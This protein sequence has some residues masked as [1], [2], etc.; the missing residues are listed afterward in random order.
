MILDGKKVSLKILQEIKKNIEAIQGLKP[1]L[2]VVL[3]GDDPASSIYVKMKRKAC[4]DSGINS[5]FIHLDSSIDEEHLI[6]EIKKLNN[7]DE[8]HGILVQFPLP[9]HIN[10][11]RVVESIIPSKDVDCFHPFNVGQLT[12]GHPTFIPCTPHGIKL[13]LEEYQIDVASKNVVIL[14]RSNLVGKPLALLLLQKQNGG[15][16]SVTVLHSQSKNIKEIC[17]QADILIAALGS[18]G[19][20]KKDFVKEGAIV[21]DVG[22]N[23]QENKIIGDVDFDEVAAKCH[24]ITPV[25]GG[26]GPMTIAALLKN[27]YQSYLQHRK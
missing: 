20:V 4:Q 7:N 18:P 24:F 26:V 9:K 23:R 10:S 6:S 27:T 1:G 15:N 13:L 14:G 25:P 16:A 3:V 8:V 11:S 19:F 12:I 22:I 21:I 17:Q 2:A 5:F